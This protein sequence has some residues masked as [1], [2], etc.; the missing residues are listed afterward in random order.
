MAV[1]AIGVLVLS[2]G[3]GA[4][5]PAPPPAPVATTVTVTPGSVAL[6]ALGETAR[7]TAE[8][9]DQNGQVMAGA[10]VAWASSDASVAAVDPS[11][12][13]TAAA[14]G[15]TIITARAGDVSADVE[16][17]VMQSAGSV[18]VTPAAATVA[19]GDTVRLV[20][21]AF[22]KNGHVVDGAEF[23]WSSRD[24]SVA[25]VDGSGLV[26]GVA[27][28]AATITAAA[29]DAR[30]TSDITVENPDRAVLVALYDAT[31]GPNWVNNENWLTDAPLEEWYGVGTDSSGRVA[32]LILRGTTLGSEVRPHGLDGPI[33]AEIGNLTKL[34]SLSLAL[35]ELSGSIP[36]ELGNL[37]N[38]EQL[39]LPDN[40]ITGLIPAELGNLTRL[41][42]LELDDNDLAGPIPGELGN[43]TGLTNLELDDNGL[44]GPIPAELGNL[45]KLTNLEL[46]GRES[47]IRG[48]RDS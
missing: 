13:V 25:T 23:N 19:P 28:G 9:R 47:R 17:S 7:L 38:L 34:V 1:A 29:G 21:E 14:N 30:G 31:D 44:A 4:V 41:T 46:N 35:N 5:V 32:H 22:D 36:P 8:V 33:P 3:D 40:R 48:S 18:V 39:E 6:S 43:L 27:E 15:G 12:L 42:D 20:A 10:T 16:V 2:C 11:G 24:A 26:Q 37:A 45:A